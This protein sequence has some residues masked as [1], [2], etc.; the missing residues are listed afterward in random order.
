MVIN[1]NKLLLA[2]VDLHQPFAHIA[3]CWTNGLSGDCILQASR[4]QQRMQVQGSV[5][6]IAPPLNESELKFGCHDV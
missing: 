2:P 1:V 4:L 6:R 5:D 3:L